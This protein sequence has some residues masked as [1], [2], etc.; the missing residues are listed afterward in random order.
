M[1]SWL[2][3]GLIAASLAVVLGWPAVATVAASVRGGDPGGEAPAG[4]LG[5]V[6]VEAGRVARPLQ[7]GTTTVG[8]VLLTEAIALPLGLPLALVLF[9]TDAW[10]RRSLI[11]LLVLSALV[12]MPLY[13][14]AWLGGF[15]NAGRLQAL[16]A[17]PLLVGLP[18]AA[19]V[20]A[21]AALPW[22]VLLAG[23][24]LRTV[25]PELE[26]SALLD[27]PAWR[28]LARVTLR[29]SLGALAGAALAVAVLTAGDMTVTDLLQV[30]TYAEEAYLQFR[31]GQGPAAASAVALPPLAILGVLIVLASR[32]LL[33]AD[34]ARLASLT[35]AGK[36]WRL[37]PW[38]LP[39]GLA[40]WATAGILLSLPLAALVWR[41]GRVGGA[42]ALGQPPH[43]SLAGLGGTL[44]LA[45]LD[46]LGTF[47]RGPL[48][49]M[50]QT[51]SWSA[52]REPGAWFGDPFSSPLLASVVWS[53]LA[54]TVTVALGWSLAW[55]SRG[56]G[57]WRGASAA[58]VALALATPG[59][60]AG[61]AL[62]R[63]Y[64]VVP[65]VYDTPV[66]IVLALVL[67]TLPYALLVLWPSVRACPP[68][69]LDAAALDG[70]GPAGQIWRVA[71][72]A[73]RGAIVAAWG[74]GFVLA[75]GELPASNLVAPPGTM[76]IAVDIWSLM[77]TGVESH[78][79]GVALIMLAAIA[80]CG[81][82]AA[83]AL[84][85]IERSSW[86]GAPAG[87]PPACV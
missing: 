66:V 36:L 43:W 12:P 84:G 56:P 71:F 46:V 67:R 27:L 30:R 74:V 39:L 14:T 69:L 79:A 40:A 16:G 48:K 41:A 64:N 86:P 55:L 33:R 51:G 76:P 53:T 57:P 8:L 47:V 59:P 60:V 4:A 63:A 58:C 34:P 6:D 78:L 31:I 26:E 68:E 19:F 22:I 45:L 7:L 35:E 80:A 77:H 24:G 72:P 25:E 38:R 17:R 75:L 13:A 3:Q 5:P 44:R 21:M 42:A 10:G 50:L 85:R 20:H 62:V 37:G 32:S 82:L 49:S 70:Y 28:V 2:A 23:V 61:M 18:G 11:G 65:I 83:R 81:M 1:R 54:A 73:T 15:G 29:R 9:R 87:Q 52:L